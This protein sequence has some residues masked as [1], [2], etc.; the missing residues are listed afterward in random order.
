[1]SEEVRRQ[2][3]EAWREE[4]IQSRRVARLM[5]ALTP[6]EMAVLAQLH[7]GLTVKLIALQAGVSEGTVRS[8]VKAI[9]RKLQS[10]P[11]WRPSRPS[12]RCVSSP[13]LQPRTTEPRGCPCQCDRQGSSG[14]QPAAPTTIIRAWLRRLSTS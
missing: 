2:T 5:E 7:D 1:M 10:V 12:G 8:Q 9:L 3:L 14:F 4:S 13:W 11:S 6:R